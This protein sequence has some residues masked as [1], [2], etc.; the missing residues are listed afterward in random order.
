MVSRRNAK[1]SDSPWRPYTIKIYLYIRRFIHKECIYI[2][3]YIYSMCMDLCFDWGTHNDPIEKTSE[4][5]E[6]L[7]YQKHH[8]MKS[9]RV[10]VM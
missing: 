10:T 2:Y 6:K 4:T 3:V 8:R 7:L 9:H 1:D 5:R